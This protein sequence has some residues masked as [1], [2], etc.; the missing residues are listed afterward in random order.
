MQ[1]AR[2][3]TLLTS[4]SFTILLKAEQQKDCKVQKLLKD[5]PDDYKTVSWK[6]GDHKYQLMVNKD[7]CFYVP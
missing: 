2:M 6:H 3:T 4:P 5:H 7:G 1:Q